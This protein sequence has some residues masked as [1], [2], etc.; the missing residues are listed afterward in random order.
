M[1]KM[2]GVILRHGVLQSNG[3]VYSRIA[4][5]EAYE[6]MK[7]RGYDVELNDAGFLVSNGIEPRD[8]KNELGI[9]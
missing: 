3:K 2:K 4:V 1:P 6:L 9:I 8:I 5:K 7:K